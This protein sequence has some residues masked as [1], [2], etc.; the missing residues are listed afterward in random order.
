[1]VRLTRNVFSNSLRRRRLYA[2]EEPS[3]PLF[4]EIGGEPNPGS[5]A[6]QRGS[7]IAGIV[8]ADNVPSPGSTGG[9]IK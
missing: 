7:S 5:I 1:M 9:Q 2:L 6:I 4:G 8:P 3:H